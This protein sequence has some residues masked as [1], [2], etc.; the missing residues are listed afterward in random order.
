LKPLKEISVD[1]LVKDVVRR[2]KAKAKTTSYD[3]LPVKICKKIFG[4]IIRKIPRTEDG[5]NLLQTTDVICL[6]H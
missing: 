1:L 6:G 3:A 4:F 5:F 2:S